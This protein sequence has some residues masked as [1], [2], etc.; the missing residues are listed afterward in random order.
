MSAEL[1]RQ[2]IE[3]IKRVMRGGM[4]EEKIKEE[5]SALRKSC[6][7]RDI[8]DFPGY[9]IT[10]SGVV[11]SSRGPW[12][13]LHTIKPYMWGGYWLVHIERNKKAASLLVHRLVCSGFHGPAPEGKPIV[14][15]LDGDRFNNRP[16]NLAWG[17]SSENARDTVRHGRSKGA[18]NFR[19][20]NM[21]NLLNR[22][23]YCKRGHLYPEVPPGKSRK[24]V[25]CSRERRK[26]PDRT[27]K[28][29]FIEGLLN[30]KMT[31]EEKIYHYR[32]RGE[33]FHLIGLRVG[34]N[35]VSVMRRYRKI[36]LAPPPEALSTAACILGRRA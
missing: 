5:L 19:N 11:W 30:K 2:E 23:P 10:D 14:R 18:E 32:T 1:I 7:V 9:Y 3:K 33:S 22:S 17:T 4:T 12:K 28:D 8:P 36:C 25:T 20:L 31:T 21:R 6:E 27:P 13:S 35:R 26:P 34:L 24:C 16:E 15:H 29:D